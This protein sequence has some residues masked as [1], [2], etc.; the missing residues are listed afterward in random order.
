MAGV[1]CS[2]VKLT[3]FLPVD[4]QASLQYDYAAVQG[5]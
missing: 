4:V 3:G 1:L 5:T 2:F